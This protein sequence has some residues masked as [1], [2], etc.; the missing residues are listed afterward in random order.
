MGEATVKW[1]RASC[2]LIW[3]A[4]LFAAPVRLGRQRPRASHCIKIITRC[5][6]HES[7]SVA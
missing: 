7:G 6:V 4:W 1:G 3:A 5:W 2:Q